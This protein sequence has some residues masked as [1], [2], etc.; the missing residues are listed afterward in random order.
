MVIKGRSLGV[1]EL[2]HFFI[3]CWVMNS[4]NQSVPLLTHKTKQ[5]R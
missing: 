2:I 1:R 3:T 4:A 5:D